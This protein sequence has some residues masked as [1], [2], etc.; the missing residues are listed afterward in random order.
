[1]SDALQI[2]RNEI[3]HRCETI[4]RNGWPCRK[5]CD[6]CCRSLHQMPVLTSAE[7]EQLRPRLTDD[8]RTRVL[9]AEG[10]VCPLLQDGVCSVYEVRPIACRTYGFYVDREGGQ[11]CSIIEAMHGLADVVW[12][13]A[14]SVERRLDAMGERRSL[15]EW[16]RTG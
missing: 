5:G 1:M 13:N 15:A 3:A 7:W 12:G 16:V 2:L 10:K 9:S 14:E 4:A 6:L 8:L 11:Y